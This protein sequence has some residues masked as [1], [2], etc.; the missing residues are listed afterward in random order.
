MSN[1]K[2]PCHEVKC[3]LSDGKP[4]LWN[5]IQG[6]SIEDVAG[7][8]LRPLTEREQAEVDQIMA[9]DDGLFAVACEQDKDA[10]LRVTYLW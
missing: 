4:V 8:C 1:S 9:D 6:Y 2:Y 3:V 7:M 10:S 5:R